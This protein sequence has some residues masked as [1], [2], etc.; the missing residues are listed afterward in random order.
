MSFSISNVSFKDNLALPRQIEKPSAAK[1]QSN[2][3]LTQNVDPLKVNQTVNLVKTALHSSPTRNAA[4]KGKENKMVS[5]PEASGKMSFSIKKSIVSLPTASPF[6]SN[7][8]LA[9]FP[10]A[11]HPLTLPTSGKPSSYVLAE[12]WIWKQVIVDCAERF[13]SKIQ[14]PKGTDPSVVRKGATVMTFPRIGSFSFPP[15]IK[16]KEHEAASVLL[17][18]FDLPPLPSENPKAK[19]SLE[20]S[21][22]EFAKPLPRVPRQKPP[23]DLSNDSPTKAQEAALLLSSFKPDPSLLDEKPQSTDSF[24]STKP[25]RGPRL[26]AFL[27]LSSPSQKSQRAALTPDLEWTNFMDQIH[28][29]PSARVHFSTLLKAYLSANQDRDSEA[30]KTALYNS[31]MTHV[32]GLEF[33]DLFRDLSQQRMSNIEKIV[34]QMP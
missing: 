28:I 11:F 24:E 1:S 32:K 15:P 26:Q 34:S 22:F 7:T 25:H 8:H 4:T 9:L 17:S 21:S 20:R 13:S 30:F 18:C 6:I 12:Q 27:A 16:H 23:V 5:S 14:D 3:A 31:P 19:D 2:A 10:H 29:P 33:I